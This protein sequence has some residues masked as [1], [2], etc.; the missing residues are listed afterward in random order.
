[1][2]FHET[3]KGLATS[4][5]GIPVKDEEAREID[6][7]LD[8]GEYSP[9]KK[10]STSVESFSPGERSDISVI[11]DGSVDSDHEIV[12]PKGL[13]FERYQ[14]NPIVTFGHNWGAPPVAKS[15]WQK[16]IG[17]HIWKAKTQY[18]S[19]PETLTKEQSW[20]PDTIWHLVKEGFLPGKSVGGLGKVR[21]ITKEEYDANPSWKSAKTIIDE[22][23]VYEYSIVPIQAN[24][25]AIVEAVAKSV[26]FFP[27]ELLQ[28][29]MPEVFEALKDSRREVDALPV[30]K[31]YTTV[32][33]YKAEVHAKFVE[34]CQQLP[35]MV[36]DVLAGVMGQV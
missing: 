8:T 25:N 6:K 32:E 17:G 14:K 35:N 10:H 27:D 4:A 12:L 22:M 9:I 30:I 7:F 20:L 19:R 2:K 24:K 18:V 5:L 36:D 11:T 29:T 34:K 16:L 26:V 1:M 23:V 15:L 3:Y 31:S 21:E 13:S 28:K 33:Q